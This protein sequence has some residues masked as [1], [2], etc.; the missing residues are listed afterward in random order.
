MNNN[1][2]SN[3][4]KKK[5]AIAN[6]C[7]GERKLMNNG[8]IRITIST[9]PNYKR[10]YEHRYILEGI[11]GRKLSFNETTHHINGDKTDNR[12]ENLKLIERKKHNKIH[13]IE[14]IKSGK[15]NGR[16]CKLGGHNG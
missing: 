1:P 2:C 9:Y 14:A 10:V 5:I 15:H 4:T 13:A 12:I 11:I 7:V 3:N 16:F 6:S 8:Y